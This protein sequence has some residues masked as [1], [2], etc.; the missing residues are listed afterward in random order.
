[1]I[2]LFYHGNGQINNVIIIIYLQSAAHV[3]LIKYRIQTCQMIHKWNRNIPNSDT[4]NIN[5]VNLLPGH[6]T[7]IISCVVCIHTLRYT[8][9]LIS[10][11]GNL[12]IY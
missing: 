4:P 11:S 8:V 1:M 6:T 5:Y 3:V 2:E 9:I 12:L 10:G 7:I